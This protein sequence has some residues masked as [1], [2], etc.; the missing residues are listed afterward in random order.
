MAWCTIDR[1][2]ARNAMT[3]AM[4][5]G[6]RRAVRL[7]N[8]DPELAALIITGSG[9]VFCPGGELGGRQEEGEDS[10]EG[11]RDDFTPFAAMRESEA[12]VVV[13]VNGICQ[14]GGLLFAM[15]ADIAVV[16]DQAEFRV[17][18]LLRG[19]PDPQFGAFL[20]AFV[21]L[22]RAKDLCLTA[23]RFGAEEAKEMGLV[24][25]VVKHNELHS[26]ARQAAEDVLQTAPGARVLAKRM[27]YEACP[28]PDMI[29]LRYMRDHSPELK[30]G[31]TAF[32]E[33]RAP[34]WVP[35]SMRERGRL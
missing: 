25:R 2:G 10:V 7:V 28:S 11:V 6:L 27:L 34:D 17:P 19:L 32:V 3:P 21:G 9:D 24:A 8:S 16:S 29:T 30:E 33:K 26:A 23:R 1:P 18:E 4:Y 31:F 15:M 5:F 20:P 14:A 35:E 13:A 22:A 12:P